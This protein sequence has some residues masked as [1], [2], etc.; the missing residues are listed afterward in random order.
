MAAATRPAPPSTPSVSSTSSSRPPGASRAGRPPW[1]ARTTPRAARSLIAPGGVNRTRTFDAA[2]RLTTETGS[3]A[4][5]ATATRALT[6]DPAGGSPSSA[7]RPGSTPTTTTTAAALAATGPSGTASR[8]TTPTATS[9]PTHRRR[10]HR[11]LQLQAGPRR[12]SRTVDR[13][14]ADPGL[15]RRRAP[16]DDRL[17]RRPRPHL[18]LR[19]LR[20][21]RQ[22]RAHEPGTNP[23]LLRQ[24]RLDHRNR[25]TRKNTS[26]VPGPATTPTATTRPAG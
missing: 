19:R 7:H 10:R 8:A 16:E 26:G 23:G 13:R 22:R 6:Y 21:P 18:R 1:T 2:G 20:P 3:G 12:P 24:L 11:R 9:P 17:R 5:A 15:Q 14:H 25:F 4:E